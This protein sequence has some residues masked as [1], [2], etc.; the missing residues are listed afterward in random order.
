MVND[1]LQKYDMFKRTYLDLQSS[2]KER[3]AL[4]NPEKGRNVTMQ[5]EAELLDNFFVTGII[6]KFNI[7]YVS[8][9][10]YLQAYMQHRCAIEIE[11]A[12][13]L[14]RQCYKQGLISEHTMHELIQLAHIHNESLNMGNNERNNLFL[15]GILQQFNAF[16][17]ILIHCK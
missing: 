6:N 10:I 13:D 4:R 9:L 5:A 15:R 11:S 3:D 17:E 2:I 14:F 7:A 1:L 16:E 12:E 8:G